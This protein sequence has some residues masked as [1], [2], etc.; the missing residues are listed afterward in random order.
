MWRTE[1]SSLDSERTDACVPVTVR[2]FANRVRQLLPARKV[3][4]S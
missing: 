4:V 3:W 1:N 2:R